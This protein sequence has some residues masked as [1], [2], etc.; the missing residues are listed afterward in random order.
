MAAHKACLIN[1]P[2]LLP[3]RTSI[4]LSNG[5][6]GP[7][8]YH[9]GNSSH[10]FRPSLLSLSTPPPPV[11]NHHQSRVSRNTSSVSTDSAISSSLH[12]RTG[13]NSFETAGGAGGCDAVFAPPPT[14]SLLV[15]T[16]VIAYSGDPPPPPTHPN[17]A[18]TAPPVGETVKRLKA[19]CF[20]VGDKITLL[21]PY[22]GFRWL[23]VRNNNNSLFINIS[24]FT[25]TNQTRAVLSPFR[26]WRYAG[27]L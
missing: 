24:S 22:D 9:R 20:A 6:G 12:V 8:T 16:A 4:L 13:S 5:G 18:S 1:V 7:A 11:N 15:C 25:L 17:I 19:L 2:T 26:F 23:Q 21:Q 27:R 3:P 10:F 14:R